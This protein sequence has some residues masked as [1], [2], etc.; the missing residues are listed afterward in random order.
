[1]KRFRP[2]SLFVV[3]VM[4]V[5]VVPTVHSQNGF[6]QTCEAHN[7]SMTALQPAWMVPPVT[8]D[9]WTA[10]DLSPAPMLGKLRRKEWSATHP[11][12][13]RDGGMQ[14]A[15]SHFHTMKHNL[16]MEGKVLL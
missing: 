4:T 1:M 11:Y 3:A 2:S 10:N 8:S 12:P 13:I 5:L 16:I 14:I 9:A 15:T 6:F 7:Q